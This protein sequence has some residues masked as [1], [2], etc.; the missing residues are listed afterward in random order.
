MWAGGSKEDKMA[1]PNQSGTTRYGVI[2][3]DPHCYADPPWSFQDWSLDFRAL[4][5]L[6]VAQLAAPNCALLLWASSRLLPRAFNLIRAWRFKYQTWG[7][8]W[9]RL[10]RPEQD[11]ASFIGSGRWMHASPELCL[12]AT[13]GNP[14]VLNKSVQRVLVELP[15]EDGRKPD[16]IREQ[17]ERLF[18]GPYL[19]L[20]ARSTKANWDC[21][22]DQLTHF[23][24]DTD[25]LKLFEH[26]NVLPHQQ[27][28]GLADTPEAP[29]P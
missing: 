22:G 27:P 8:C 26:G 10:T 18:P 17:I 13:R 16:C 11:G 2:Y 1:I 12:L 23:S 3:A 20:C 29:G 21:W 15:R 28:S 4:A 19:E 7:F 14:E 9:L 24:R 5:A 25:Q 6:P